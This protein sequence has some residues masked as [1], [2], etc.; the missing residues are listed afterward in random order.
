MSIEYT[1]GIIEESLNDIGVLSKI[2]MF[3]HTS[4][5]TNLP[6]EEPDIWHI[7]EYHI[8]EAALTSLIPELK[9]NIK[10]GW[11]IH[12]FNIE[13]RKLHVVLKGKNFLLP[14]KKDD[15]WDV[16]ISYGQSV[17]CESRWTK[18]IPLSV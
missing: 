18:N 14:T 13:A 11:Y 9:K 5:V 7:N 16:M 10:E 1:C 4:R 15:S 3:L 2:S 6:D 12:A 8:P 17:G